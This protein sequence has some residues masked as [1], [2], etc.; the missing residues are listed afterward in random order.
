MWWAKPSWKGSEP[1]QAELAGHS[2]F[3]AENDLIPFKIIFYGLIFEPKQ[4]NFRLS[5][6]SSRAKPKQSWYFL[7]RTHHY[8]Y[9]NLSNRDLCWGENKWKTFFSY[10]TALPLLAKPDFGIDKNGLSC[11][12]SLWGFAI[13]RLGYYFLFFFWAY[14]VQNFNENGRRKL[15][16][17][18]KGGLLLK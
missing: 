11:R 15:Q 10:F 1:S 17:H 9:S 7:A 16:M 8:R 3:W 5:R 12:M 14:K 13:Q 2:N 6:K 18:I 4:W